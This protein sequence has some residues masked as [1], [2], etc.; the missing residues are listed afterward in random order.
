V[1]AA[2]ATLESKQGVSWA[3]GSGAGLAF[4]RRKQGRPS[5][6]RSGLAKFFPC[7]LGGVAQLLEQ[8]III[9]GRR[10]SR[11]PLLHGPRS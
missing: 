2:A 10:S 3:H 1:E 4:C 6:P 8:R 7:N 11:P 5:R 9:R